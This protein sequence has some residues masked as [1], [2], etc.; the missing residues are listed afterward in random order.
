MQFSHVNDNVPFSFAEHIL[1]KTIKKG[2]SQTHY[3]AI[4][5]GLDYLFAKFKKES[6][7]KYFWESDSKRSFVVDILPVLES[8]LAFF[9]FRG[10]I[11]N[12]VLS[13]FNDF[14]IFVSTLEH[15]LGLVFC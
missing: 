14:K 13:K 10:E 6:V 9:L 2:I 7:I 15:Y 1:V 5:V 4:K 8:Y 12:A 11:E 3:F